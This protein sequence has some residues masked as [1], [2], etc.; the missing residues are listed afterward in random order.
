M[1]YKIYLKNHNNLPASKEEKVHLNIQKKIKYNEQIFILWLFNIQKFRRNRSFLLNVRRKN[2]LPV[3]K[4]S[5]IY[6]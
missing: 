5:I 1:K 2:A 4:P 3:N 6:V